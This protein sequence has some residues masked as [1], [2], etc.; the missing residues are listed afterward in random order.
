M[1]APPLENRNYDQ[2]IL[3][4]RATL[5][6]LRV[7]PSLHD[8]LYIIASYEE[9]YAL[10]SAPYDRPLST[11]LLAWAKPYSAQEGAGVYVHTPR[12][13]VLREDKALIRK[14]DPF[15][16]LARTFPIV[17]YDSEFSKARTFAHHYIER[18]Y[19]AALRHAERQSSS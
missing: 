12:L 6:T 1:D 2:R 5:S 15:Q 10:Y 8:I 17:F 19:E 14:R 13:K 11:K 18:C 7:S 16:L 9:G 3:E 4:Q